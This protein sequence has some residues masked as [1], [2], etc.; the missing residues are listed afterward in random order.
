[1]GRLT[2]VVIFKADEAEHCNLLATTQA[3][4]IDNLFED[5]EEI[6]PDD[7][8]GIT[9]L[10]GT[11]GTTGTAAT[12]V[13]STENS[14]RSGRNSANTTALNNLK[15]TLAATRAKQEAAADRLYRNSE[16]GAW[17][18]YTC[19]TLTARTSYFGNCKTAENTYKTAAVADANDDNFATTI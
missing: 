7:G 14:A 9:N 8:D 17:N 16:Q 4:I 12:S 11:I 5:L 2:S 3:E 19:A 18:A 1:M 6:A 10:L 15:T 13:L